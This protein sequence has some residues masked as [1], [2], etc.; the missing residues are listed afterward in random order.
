MNIIK[1]LKAADKYV[2]MKV[3]NPKDSE[4]KAKITAKVPL[5]E[6]ALAKL[7][8]KRAI[9]VFEESQTRRSSQNKGEFTLGFNSTMNEHSIIE[10]GTPSTPREQ[11]IS[12]SNYIGVH[13]SFAQSVKT[14][15][16]S[17]KTDT[18]SKQSDQGITKDMKIG[19]LVK[20][21]TF[22]D[23]KLAEIAA[24]VDE[25]KAYLRATI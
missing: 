5:L 22:A 18:I 8:E 20:D 17:I 12:F 2:L 14:L 6:K 21:E 7:K 16:N 10:H 15:F 4:V 1:V 9:L 13:D 11:D 24:K 3:K 23:A 25:L 19:V